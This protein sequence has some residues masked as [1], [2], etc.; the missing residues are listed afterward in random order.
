MK[1]STGQTF[2]QI[3]TV[4]PNLTFYRVMRGFHRTFATGVGMPTGD[5]YSSSYL[6]TPHLELAYVLHVETNPF[7][8]PVKKLFQD[9]ALWEFFGTFSILLRKKL[10]IRRIRSASN[11]IALKNTSTTDQ[12]N[13]SRKTDT[14][15]PPFYSF[16]FLKSMDD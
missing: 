16:T 12:V 3:I 11:Y 8:R 13:K 2:N 4:L 6:V 5:A 1:L 14:T 15:N 7:P 10:G 9:L